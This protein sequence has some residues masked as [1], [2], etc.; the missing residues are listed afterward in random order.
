MKH[1]S[2]SQLFNEQLAHIG[3]QRATIVLDN[4]IPVEKSIQQILRL[5][6]LSNLSMVIK[7]KNSAYS[8]KY[9]YKKKDQKLIAVKLLD[10]STR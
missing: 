4:F 1:I 7:V 9:S 5:T 2:P 10:S 8:I 3:E 6:N